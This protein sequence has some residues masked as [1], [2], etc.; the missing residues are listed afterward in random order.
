MFL[1]RQHATVFLTSM[2][3][4]FDSCFLAS[5]FP[6]TALRAAVQRMCQPRKY[7]TALA[8]PHSDIFDEF[9]SCLKNGTLHFQH[10]LRRT[11]LLI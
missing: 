8:S 11:M 10:Y 9:P 4:D 1:R 6:S 3:A 5:L 7:C 2:I